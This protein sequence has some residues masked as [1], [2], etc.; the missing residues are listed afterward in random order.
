MDS[1]FNRTI[2]E[3]PLLVVARAWFAQLLASQAGG[4]SFVTLSTNER[5]GKSKRE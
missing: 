3:F 1:G 2:Y 4:L 5:V